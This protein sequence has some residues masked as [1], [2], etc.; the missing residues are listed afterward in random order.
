[1]KK[2]RNLKRKIPFLRNKWFKIMNLTFL[3]LTI[4]LLQVSASVYSQTTRLN[5]GSDGTVAYSNNSQQRMV[6]GKVTDSEGQPLPGVSIVLRGTAQGTVTNADGNYTLT[7][8][9]GD[10]VLVFS[11]VGMKTQEVVVGNQTNINLT[12]E[13]ESIGL[14]E[15]VAIGYGTVKSSQ[16]SGSVV[17]IGYETLQERS[18]G[19]VDQALIGKLAGVY[20]Q[21]KSGAP[22]RALDIKIRGVKSLNYSNDPLYVIDG[23]PVDGNLLNVNT[24]DIESIEVLKDAASAAIYGSRASNGVV[25]ITTKSGKMGKSEISFNAY[26]GVQKRLSKYDVLSRDEWIDFAIDERNNTWELRGGNKNDPNEKRSSTAYWIDP[27]WSNPESLPN[28]DWQELISRIAPI[29]NYQLSASGAFD[30]AKYYISGTYFDQDGILLNT[31]SKRFSFQSNVETVFSKIINLG[32]NLTASSSVISDPETDQGTAIISRS[33]MM[34]PVVGIDEN[35]ERGGYNPYVLSALVNPYHW[36][37]ETMDETK[38]NYLLA[39]IYFELN[40]TKNLIWRSSLGMERRN[41]FQEYFKPNNV[42]RNNGSIGTVRSGMRNNHLTEHLLKYNIEKPS[43]IFNALGGFTY[44]ADLYK[45]MDLSKRDFPDESI[46]TLNVA[47]TYTSG[48]SSASQWRL[49]SFLG[50]LNLFIKD[51][52]LFTANIRRDGS[53]RFGSDRRWGWFPSLSAG[54]RLTE[55]DFMKGIDWLSNMKLRVSYGMVGNND[56]GNYSAIG[57]LGNYNAILGEPQNLVPGA[58]PASFSNTLLGWEKTA[59]TNFGVEVGFLKDRFQISTDYF[60]ANTYDL[61]VN[62]E[63]P[64]VTGFGNSVQNVGKIQNKGLEFEISSVNINKAFKWNTSFNISTV[65]NEVLELGRDGAPIYGYQFGFNMTITEIGQPAGSYYMFKQEGV[66]MDQA[67]FDSHPHYKQQ[68]VGDIKYLDYNKD[69]VIDN[70]D[71]HIVGDP[72]PDFYWGLENSFSYKNF[73]LSISIDGQHGA[74][75]LFSFMRSGGQSRGNELSFWKNRWRSEE[76]PGDGMTP[77]AV[78]STNM[79]TPSSFWLFDATYWMVRNINLGY[80]FPTDLSSKI[81]GVR[82]LRLYA[83]V[84]NPFIHDHFHG[85]PM[86][87]SLGNTATLPNNEYSTYPFATTYT[88]GINLKF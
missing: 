7:N 85:T 11:F 63:I 30:L 13:Q 37:I 19:R 60:I 42:N 20:T 26:Y 10:A 31:S 28:N 21:D 16:L 56:I 36:L 88:F 39:N 58:A 25:I 46:Y 34:P 29:Q 62:L 3:F 59:T 81:P 5:E 40:L 38:N 48:G 22:G 4:G 1:M 2:I 41:I 44:Q 15:V 32:L 14:E 61:L 9:P 53:S 24:N 12:L 33:W 73:D 65:K 6:S 87:S 86:A 83:R 79:T 74:D 64:T 75:G 57:T 78:V 84:E 8:I 43:W 35:T 55:E 67:D 54:W 69:D 23:Y 51:R 76:D 68:Q 80:N 17:K 66:Y 52:Y 72:Y 18:V 49:M 71:V 50:R 82:S 47:S 27:A 70:D 77:R 45:S